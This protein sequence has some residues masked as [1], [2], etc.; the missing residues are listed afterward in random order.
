[1]KKKI[2]RSSKTRARVASKSKKKA[3]YKSFPVKFSFISVTIL[4]CLALVGAG[5]YQ[6]VPQANVLGTG[7]FRCVYV[8]SSN[9]ITRSC[10]LGYSSS[11]YGIYTDKTKCVPDPGQGKMSSSE[12]QTL[13]HTIYVRVVDAKNS[14]K[15]SIYQGV[16]IH[17][18]GSSKSGTQ[19]ANVDSK[20]YARL[21]NY[22]DGN[23]ANK[24]TITVAGNKSGSYSFRPTSQS[25]YPGTANVACG[26]SNNP[27][28]FKV[29]ATTLCSHTCIPAQAC[30]GYGGKPDDSK[31]CSN[32]GVCCTL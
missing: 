30:H 27:C 2:I 3:W 15:L 26:I 10:Y 19:T 22:G 8:T 23:F 1:M 28:V 21:Y 11:G 18:I 29:T 13:G 4:G 5:L 16:G 25:I 31:K 9:P 20:G 17:V 32:S 12:C 24:V 7:S 6:V 14:A